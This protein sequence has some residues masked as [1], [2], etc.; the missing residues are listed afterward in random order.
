MKTCVLLPAYNVE[1]S[2]GDLIEQLLRYGHG[3]IVINDGSLDATKAVA[4]R[5]AKHGV[6]LINHPENFGK[7]RALRSGFKWAMDHG[8]EVVS[9]MD[10]DLQHAS[11]DLPDMLDVFH[12]QGLD[13]LIGDRMHDQ[14][15]MPYGR[16]L[17]NRFSSWIAGIYCHQ[18]IFDVQCGLRIFRMETCKKMFKELKLDRYV[19]ESE[20]VVRSSLNLL[21]IGFTPI[22]VIYPEDLEYKSFY[23]PCIDTIR[24][25]NYFIGEFC[26]RT[27]TVEGRRELRELNR[28]VKSCSDWPRYYLLSG[29]GSK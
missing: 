13:V 27:F 16:R 23:R 1:S 18:K 4:E 15:D 11:S 24:I 25:F 21:R 29:Q 2:L 9:A 7:G 12:G 22:T 3:L 8:F 6:G 17:G 5:Y 28:Y 10:S 20:V 14:T 26:R 19:L